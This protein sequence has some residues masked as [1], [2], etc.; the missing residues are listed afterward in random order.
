[1]MPEHDEIYGKY[2]ENYEE[3]VS[4]ED[5]QHNLL[6][7]LLKIADFKGKDIIELGG[8]TGRISLQIAPLAH[9]I[10]IFE[11]SPYMLSL[12]EEKLKKKSLKNWTVAAADSRFIPVKNNM[13]HTVIS[14]WSIS[15]IVQWNFNIWEKE[16]NRVFDEINRILQPG[17]TILIIETL[18]TGYKTPFLRDEK[19]KLYYSYLEKE[20]LFD[21]TSIRTD[22]EFSNIDEADRILRFF[23]GD[24][25]T[26]YIIKE[27]NYMEEN[28]HIII[29]ECTGIWWKRLNRT[30]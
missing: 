21:R 19:L 13:A 3:L 7:A 26:D 4:K 25:L 15:Y 1:M 29:P 30:E 10:N 27:K 23:F 24:N 14:G 12:A 11:L 16:L 28:N 2:V 5:Y 22:Y 8:G 17:G 20:L 6:P 18:G 9:S